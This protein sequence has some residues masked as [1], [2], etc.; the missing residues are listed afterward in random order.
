MPVAP[1]AVLRRLVT[2]SK[3]A[4]ACVCRKYLHCGDPSWHDSRHAMDQKKSHRK[5][6]KVPV[7]VHHMALPLQPILIVLV[8]M[9][10]MSLLAHVVVVVLGTTGQATGARAQ[11]YS[12]V[13]ALEF[14]DEEADEAG[15]SDPDEATDPAMLLEKRGRGRRSTS[16]S[17]FARMGQKMFGDRQLCVSNWSE[18]KQGFFKTGEEFCK[19]HHKFDG[20]VEKKK[21]RS[22]SYGTGNF[23]YCN[24]CRGRSKLHGYCHN[25]KFYDRKDVRQ[26]RADR[27][28][29]VAPTPDEVKAINDEAADKTISSIKAAL[30]AQTPK[31]NEDAL[32]E[33]I[34]A[35]M[36]KGPGYTLPRW[37]GAYGKWAV[38]GV[39]VIATALATTALAVV[40]NAA[41]VI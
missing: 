5:A 24:N 31:I 29:D 17:M 38:L 19:H 36:S 39:H 9:T 8:F 37:Y 11:A 25:A 16:K 6:G 12:G 32:V 20:A 2:F 3:H 26:W 21:C 1:L 33:K 27:G 14:E 41:D 15:E 40:P 23:N 7:T 22:V 30:A 18:G 4:L 35:A 13:R 10:I 28:Y 34:R